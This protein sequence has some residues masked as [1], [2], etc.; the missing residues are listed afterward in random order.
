MINIEYLLQLAL[1]KL[2]FLAFSLAVEK[3]RW[4][5]FEKGPIGM[6]SRWWG[7]SMHTISL[8]DTQKTHSFQFEIV[9]K[10]LSKP[11]SYNIIIIHAFFSLFQLANAIQN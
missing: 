2:P 5:V 10:V 9:R 11:N 6:N 3:W 7:R 4:H 8:H 1:E